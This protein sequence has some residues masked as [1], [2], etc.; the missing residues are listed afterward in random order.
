MIQ[1]RLS[2]SLPLPPGCGRLNAGTNQGDD[3]ERRDVVLEGAVRVL[4][5]KVP[6]PYLLVRHCAVLV[7]GRVHLLVGLSAKRIRLLRNKKPSRRRFARLKSANARGRFGG[8]WGH[9][10]RTTFL[11]CTLYLTESRQLVWVDSV[12][13][14]QNQFE[15]TR[16]REVWVLVGK[17]FALNE[18]AK[19]NF[20]CRRNFKQ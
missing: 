9:V 16:I 7:P 14:M 17:H 10:I 15:S 19:R 1:Q 20:T 13:C 2:L 8:G 11:P 3:V 12:A 5:V 18:Q 4:R 6:P